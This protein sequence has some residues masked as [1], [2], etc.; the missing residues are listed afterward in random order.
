MSCSIRLKTY[1]KEEL[2]KIRSRINLNIENDANGI[3]LATLEKKF[4]SAYNDISKNISPTESLSH[5][6]SN[7]KNILFVAA[8]KELTDVFE[9]RFGSNSKVKLALED[10]SY[11]KDTLVSTMV[12]KNV[13]TGSTGTYK[14]LIGTNKSI[15]TGKGAQ[16]YV[17]NMDI[18]INKLL[19][20]RNSLHQTDKATG[21][22]ELAKIK[23]SLLLGSSHGKLNMKGSKKRKGYTHGD[24]DDMKNLLEELDVMDMGSSP[25]GYID[26]AKELLDSMH[27]HFFREMDIYIKNARK[28]VGGFVDIKAKNMLLAVSKDKT[29]QKSNAE[30]YLHEVFHSITHWAMNQKEASHIMRE[31]DHVFKLAGSKITW[32]DY[33]DSSKEKTSLEV[34]RAK[35][36]WEYIFNSENAKEEFVAHAMTHPKTKELLRNITSIST[37]DKK[38]ETLLDKIMDFVFTAIDIVLGNYKFT[39]RN[40]DAQEQVHALAFRLAEINTRTEADMARKNWWG[41]LNT[42]IDNTEDKFQLWAEGFQN[43]YFDKKDK[44]VAPEDGNSLKGLVFGFE[45]VGKALVSKKYRNLIGLTLDSWSKVGIPIKADGTVREF[46]RGFFTPSDSERL[47]SHMGI[48]GAHID[49]ERNSVIEQTYATLANDFITK[50]NEEMSSALTRTV[51]DTNLSSLLSTVKGVDS[52]RAY[53]NADLREILTDDKKRNYRQMKAKERL[54]E[55]VKNTDRE[56]TYNWIVSQAEGL[57]YF[58]ATHN[59]FQDQNT[60]A[61]N[62]VKGYMSNQRFTIDKNIL[63]LVEEISVLHAVGNTDTKQRNL[64]AEVM[65]DEW[66]G[67]NTLMNTYES[68]KTQSKSKNFKDDEAHIMDGYS[69]EIFD[70]G[71]DVIYETL[72]SKEEL[73]KA[74]YEFHGIVRPMHGEI[75]HKDIGMFVLKGFGRTEMLKGATSLSKNSARGTSLKEIKYMENSE[76][77]GRLFERDKARINVTAKEMYLKRLKGEKLDYKGLDNSLLPIIDRN[78]KVVDYRYMMSKKRKEEIL[79]QDTDALAVMARSMGSLIDKELRDEHN[80]RVLGAIK[81]IMEDDWEEGTGLGKD[82][83]E[84]SLI[85]PKS[86]NPEML[87]IYYKLPKNMQDFINSRSDKT[88]AVPTS[89]LPIFFGYRHWSLAEFSKGKVPLWATRL[90]ALVENFYIDLISIL[91]GN[92]LLKMPAILISN[93]VSNAIYLLMTTGMSPAELL[94]EHKES[95]QAAKSYLNSYRDVKNLTVQ[96]GQEKARANIKGVRNADTIK[97]L[98]WKI[99]TLRKEMESNSIHELFEAGLFQSVVEDVNM[100]V[101]GDNNKV[102]ET[103]DKIL[104]KGPVIVKKGLQYAYL[105]KETGWYKFNQEVLQLSDLVARDIKNK[106][107]KFAEKQMLKGERVIPRHIREKMGIADGKAILT[108]AQKEKFAELSKQN[109]LNTLLDSFIDYNKP[110]GKFEE[111]LNRIGLLMF[112]K[113]FKRIQRVIGN[114]AISNPIRFTIYAALAALAIDLDSIDDQAFLTKGFGADG[115]FGFG[116]LLP[117][118]NPISN[119]MEVI[120][121]ALVKPETSMGLLF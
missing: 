116:N 17:A 4:A 58:M 8:R 7:E 79:G 48:Q 47:A 83:E 113:Y 53:T 95:W 15:P 50:P 30:V 75:R 28:H 86:E 42:V 43:K 63:A 5:T 71:T 25:E 3:N 27:P 21:N 18:V 56:K 40:N 31:L 119:V 54:K 100:N 24:I 98:E 36:T 10:V 94:K 37:K 68:F 46:V 14:F 87:E 34:S 32:E 55:H 19:K 11:D 88:M 22:K 80:E 59:G 29:K 16:L 60:S 38:R 104:S 23:A 73:L 61:R 62:I 64:A 72:D 1:V 110:N 84:F 114:T 33:L 111:Y 39:E 121:P 93:I 20:V 77:G 89:M 70:S 78:G 26:E 2:H 90:I 44:I 109:R 35:A 66:K 108:L 13:G 112:T 85:G 12:L 69:K 115:D 76:L 74:G 57:G 117:L 82:L 103:A 101:L 51:L 67:V 97:S 6:I 96:L 45:V 52:K 65:K 118:Y 81:Q 107:M 91:K 49:T 102:T 120:T 92:I 105:S 41:S 106:K 99:S 9:G